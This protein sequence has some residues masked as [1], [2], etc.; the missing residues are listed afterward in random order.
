V[1]GVITSLTGGVGV[2]MTTPTKYATADQKDPKFDVIW[3][4]LMTISILKKY[5]GKLYYTVRTKIYWLC[6]DHFLLSAVN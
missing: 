4:L 3:L 2:S 1:G 6:K 5:I